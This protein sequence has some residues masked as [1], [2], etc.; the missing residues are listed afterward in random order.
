MFQFITGRVKILPSS[1]RGII[2]VLLA[3]A[4]AG[5]VAHAQSPS[6]A[7]QRPFPDPSF[8]TGDL[9]PDFS[10]P[11]RSGKA[12]R[13]SELA[14]GDTLLLFTCGCANCL[15]LETYL[16]RLIR[17]LGN[18]APRVVDV[19]LTSPEQEAARRRDTGLRETPLYI[20][21]ENPVFQEYRGHPCP[22]VYRLNPD[23]RVAWI[24]PS[25]RAVR[26]MR[27]IAEALA[28]ELGLP[29]AA[30]GPEPDRTRRPAP[31]DSPRR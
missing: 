12:R 15:A 22:R 27:A 28:V 11:D 14:R 5:V 13:L 16:A 8:R 1:R 20:R 19:T 29:A 3:A 2:S 17:Q 7:V 23:R 21:R 9:A 30:V 24:G 18:R 4:V 10:L 26:S 31:P 6:N 25:P